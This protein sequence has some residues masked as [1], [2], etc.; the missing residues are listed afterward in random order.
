MHNTTEG[1]LSKATRAQ[2]HAVDESLANGA[3]PSK[4]FTW[5]LTIAILS[6]SVSNVQIT[7]FHRDLLT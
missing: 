2:E 5:P 1:D 6:L 4:V 7:L 3:I